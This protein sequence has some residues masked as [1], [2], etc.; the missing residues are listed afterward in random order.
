MGRPILIGCANKAT[1]TTTTNLS[2]LKL[3]YSNE[4]KWALIS[5]HLLSTRAWHFRCSVTGG[6]TVVVKSEI[7]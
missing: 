5:N 1:T 2:A 3:P 6:L 7:S 4:P